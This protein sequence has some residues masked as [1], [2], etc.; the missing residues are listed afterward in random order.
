MKRYKKIIVSLLFGFIIL[1]MS[2]VRAHAEDQGYYIKNMKVDVVVNDKRQYIITE[3]LD[4]YFN[5]KRHGIKRDI[6][7][8]TN[9]EEYSITDISV[10]GAPVDIERGKDITLKIGDKDKSI[11]GD[12]EYVIK[13][14][15]NNY[16]DEQPDGDYIYLNLLPFWD[17]KVENFE[18]NITYPKDAK[19]ENISLTDGPQGSKTNELTKYT[20]DNNTIKIK[21]LKEIGTFNG[22]TVNARLNEG[23]LKNAPIKTYPITI[24][25]DIMNVKIIKEKEYLIEREFEIA[26]NELNKTNSPN[27][28]YLLDKSKKERLKSISVEGNLIKA[29]KDNLRIE[30]P[31]SIGTYRFKVNYVVKPTLKS[32][33]LIDIMGT[34][35]EGKTESFTVN[36]KSDVPI[37]KY[38][39][40]FIGKGFNLGK[41]RYVISQK[42]NEIVFN[43]LNT[44]YPKER[45]NLFLESDNSLF[46][47]E[48]S[49][50]AKISKILSIAVL[51]ISTVLYLI[52]RDKKKYAS[53]VE[54]YPPEG[55]SSA[56]VGFAYKRYS[57]KRDITSLIFY[58]ASHGHLK[59]EF[60]ESDEFKLKRESELDSEHKLFERKLFSALFRIGKG[61]SVSEAK[62]RDGALSNDLNLAAM[63]V[64]S[65]F[66]GE[67]KL[68]DSKSR[69]ISVLGLLISFIPVVL[70]ALSSI[71]WNNSSVVEV[72]R[73]VIIGIGQLILVYLIMYLMNALNCNKK[74]PIL[75]AIGCT[76]IGAIYGIAVFTEGIFLECNIYSL[77]ITIISTL[78]PVVLFSRIPKRSSYGRDVLEKILG[79]RNFI[80]IAEK[81]SL[82]ALLEEN[83]EYFYKTLPFAQVLNVTDLWIDKFKDIEM[84]KPSYYDGYNDLSTY[85][86]M[87]RISSDMNT[88]SSTATSYTPTSSGDGGFSGGGFSGGGSGG[89]GG[90]SW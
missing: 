63:D 31:N 24:K 6:P 59:I 2:Y 76:F 8:E 5:D 47:R 27:Y 71:E 23:S 86:F 28:M 38:N 75:C 26:V 30:I 4:V 64:Y 90:S 37:K 36:L 49:N 16:N 39:L 1:N 58:W 80:E 9:T 83:P 66:K 56:E 46:K 25:K 18:A 68:T 15:I 21:S 32:D 45:I 73:I 51:V 65:L 87:N 40:E 88:I 19:L 62:L 54:F 3:T 20:I 14:T 11:Q 43:T 57:Q 22:V 77:V 74:V 55:M 41:D 50:G 78:L 72:W 12:K 79:F 61:T 84:I 13:Y 48:E 82:E 34:L 53:A 42:G 85:Y 35:R 10:E 69:V 52:F 44:V 29:D 17:T 7:V 89:G 60:N 33:I 81:P 67:R 70:F